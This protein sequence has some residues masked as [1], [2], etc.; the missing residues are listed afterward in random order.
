MNAR[1]NFAS[2][3]QV[4]RWA[5]TVTVACL[6]AR[7]LIP[8]GYMPGNILDGEFMVLCPAG[9]G[10]GAI[11]GLH[12]GHNGHN[13]DSDSVVDA[14]RTC[15]LGTALKYAALPTNEITLFETSKSPVVRDV[16]GDDV[17]DSEVP[18]GFRSRAP[19]RM[20]FQLI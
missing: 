18:P 2:V 6:L 20:R 4:R 15:P 3:R 9:I 10:A 11:T 17:S 16:S 19:P 13:A 5:G 8:L 7:A 1:G 12:R 14:D